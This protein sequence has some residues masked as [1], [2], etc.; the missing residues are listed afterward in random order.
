MNECFNTRLILQRV[1]QVN[2]LKCLQACDFSF[3]ET[4]GTQF[5]MFRLAPLSY[6]QNIRENKI[7]GVMGIEPG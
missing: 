4:Q 7:F 3:I 6:H 5:T 1:K 2:A